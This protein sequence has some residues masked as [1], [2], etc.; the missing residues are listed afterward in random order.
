MIPPCIGFLLYP[1]MVLQACIEFLY[2][3]GTETVYLNAYRHI[4]TTQ[5]CVDMWFIKVILL[6]APR[7]GKTTMRRRLAGEIKDI[8][9]S[10]EGEQPSTGTVE[11]GPSVIIRN[12]SSTTALVTPSKWLVTDDLTEE[13]RVFL[14]YFHNSI[15][16]ARSTRIGLRDSESS[17]KGVV[18]RNEKGKVVSETVVKRTGKKTVSIKSSAGISARGSP[19]HSSTSVAFASSAS[20]P[21]SPKSSTSMPSS[22]TITAPKHASSNRQGQLKIRIPD[23][24]LNAVSSK[25]WKEISKVYKG[26]AI[27][28]MG[29]TGGQPEFMDMLPV[30][31]IGPALYLLFCKL[32]DELLSL[33][34]VSYLSTSGESTLPIQSTYT[35]EEVIF[36]T[37][38]SIACLR[39]SSNIA[40]PSSEE[41]TS[42]TV[43]QL[44]ASCNKSVAY[45]VGTHKD[46]VSEEQIASFDEKLQQSLRPTA[47]FKEDIVQYASEE[48]MVLP[49]DNMRG[50]SSEVQN[51]RKL[52]DKCLKEHFEK[53]S[54]PAS[55]L[56]L[57]LHLRNREVRTASLESVLQLASDL[58][59][60][61]S[62][63]MV[64]LWFLH[65]YAGVLMYFSD[66][67]ELKDTVIC[68]N[69]I[70]YDSTTNLIV[71]TFR[72]GP[73]G[74][75]ASDWFK[76]TGLFSLEDIRKVTA[77]VSGDYIPLKQL[78]K[79]LQHLNIL[80]SFIQHPSNPMA[81]T[82]CTTAPKEMHFMPCVLQN[83]THE[84]LKEWLDGI[85]QQISPA[86][87][88]IRYKCG[89]VPIGVFPAMIANL[90]GSQPLTA[91]LMWEGMKKNRVQFHIGNDFD[92]ITLI[93]QPKYYAVHISRRKSAKTPTYELCATV[94]EL[95]ESTLK[96]VTSRMNYKFTAEYQLGFECP[97]HPG[98]EHLCVV[99][100]DDPSPHIMCCLEN[101][102][103]PT[104]VDMQPQHLVWFGNVSKIFMHIV[105]VAI[106]VM[107]LLFL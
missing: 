90:A 28:K 27:I 78:V 55:W 63:A 3:I 79:L 62:E 4:L 49:V 1:C 75:S 47:F 34:N 101:V 77:G 100:G 86:P 61:Q 103:S 107:L 23:M 7:L 14:Q 71:N 60:S 19:N 98:R 13:V 89:F 41:T 67:P 94:R 26:T 83:A 70:V 72:V 42:S 66:L 87:L 51:I 99:D 73:V 81:L 80:A 18:H 84:E 76:K 8:S 2:L 69:Q 95:V 22:S 40:L 45:I 9:S 20:A 30:L 52:L 5:E 16:G 91:K 25:H 29:D 54:I 97:S 12:L 74:K 57:S 59:I 64:A 35:M 92:T 37:L 38:A 31:T 82:S 58:G 53:L 33:Y 6:G 21:T 105:L 43:N 11:S 10:G 17:A 85:T 44:M 39:S 93:S 104:P 46:L 88:M 56:V 15:S 48:R 65:H 106:A 36:A 50:G 102:H 24:V 32:T 68:D 96:T